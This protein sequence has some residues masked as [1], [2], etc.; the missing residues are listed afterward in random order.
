MTSGSSIKWGT[1][2]IQ[3]IEKLPAINTMPDNEIISNKQPFLIPPSS[4]RPF[5][6]ESCREKSQL[7]QTTKNVII[8]FFPVCCTN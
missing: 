8:F 7:I 2:N 1:I 6:R 4:Q 5:G 3:S